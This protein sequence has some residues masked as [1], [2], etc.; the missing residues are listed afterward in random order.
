[1]LTY[2]IIKQQVKSYLLNKSHNYDT[3]GPEFKITRYN[4][5]RER[6]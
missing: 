4:V 5:M 1:M 2:L 6:S 3:I